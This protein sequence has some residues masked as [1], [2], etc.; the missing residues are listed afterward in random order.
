MSDSVIDWM[1]IQ[2]VRRIR[3]KIDNQVGDRARYEVWM[4]VWEPIKDSNWYLVRDQICY[5]VSGDE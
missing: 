4:R 5:E 1:M 2:G 3:H